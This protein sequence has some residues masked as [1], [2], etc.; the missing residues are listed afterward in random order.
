MRS[1]ATVSGLA[2]TILGLAFWI[3]IATSHS[4]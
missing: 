4:I 2:G 3:A 1:F